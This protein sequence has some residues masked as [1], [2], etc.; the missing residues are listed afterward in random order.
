MTT[1]TTGAIDYAQTESAIGL[2]WYEIDPNLSKLMDRY[3]S[4]ADRDWAE[5]ILR[6]WGELCG[7]PIAERA[8][9]IDKN[10]PRLERYDRMGEEIA[11]IV[12]HPSAID[13]KRDIWNEGP[14]GVAARDGRDQA[15]LAREVG[16]EL[17][18]QE[19]RAF[20]GPLEDL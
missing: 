12:H 10:P 4:P 20:L 3:V 9:I 13:Q 14:T 11:S 6:R 17:I 1:K 16:H 8:E 2:N 7:G 18:G 5:G 19:V 15:T